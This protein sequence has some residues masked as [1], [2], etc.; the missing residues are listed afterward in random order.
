V[1]SF[2]ATSAYNYD[3]FLRLRPG[4]KLDRIS[5]ITSNKKNFPGHLKRLKFIHALRNSDLASKI[6]FWGGG[7]NPIPDKMDGIY[8]YKY[9]IVLENASIPDYWTEKLADSFLGLSYP[10]Y[11]GCPNIKSYFPEGSLQEINISKPESAISL[12]KSHFYNYTYEN[13][14]AGILKAQSLVLNEYNIFATLSSICDV[15]SKI[16]K[17]ISLC[18][19]SHFPNL[20][21]LPTMPVDILLH[22]LISKVN[23]SWR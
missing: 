5:V 14:L 1:H 11:Y 6:D 4:S 17:Q 18:P 3:A 7:H 9:H 19:P 16:K 23:A 21:R 22:K 20:D 2:K 12:I 13:S 15:K 8:P 10:F